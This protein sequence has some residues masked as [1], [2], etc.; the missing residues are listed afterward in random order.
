MDDKIFMFISG[1]YVD[2]TEMGSAELYCLLN[3]ID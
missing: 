1:E 2:V 3:G